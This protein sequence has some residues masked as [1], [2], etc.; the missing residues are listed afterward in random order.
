MKKICVV[1]GSRAEYGLL[2]NLMKK[3]NKDKN[4][5]L[6][7]IATCM[8]LLPKFGLTYKEIIKDGF[9]INWTVKM[10]ISSSKPINVTK[11]TGLG[12]VGF[13]KAFAKLKPDIIIILGD[14]FE[15]LSAA[16]AALSEKIPIAHIHGGESTTGVIDEAIRHS[17]SKMS[18][19]H[20]VATKKYGKRIMQ[21]GENPNRIY[22]V[23]S[24]GVD[25]IKNIKLYSKD[26]LEKKINFKLG[27][28]NILV[29]YHP[30]TLNN[31]S[32][33]KDIEAIIQSIQK[34]KK[35]KI[36][37]TLPNADSGSEVILKTIKN[38][39][40]KNKNRSIAF[41]SMGDKLYLSTMKNSDLVLG[42]SSSGIIEAPSFKIPTINVG[43]RQN[44]RIKAGSI[45]DCDAKYSS[46]KQAIKKAFSKKFNKKISKVKNPYELK[47]TSCKIFN[48]LKKLKTDNVLKKDFY[49]LP[50]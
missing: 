29:T 3:L 39:V 22:L 15:I 17:V 38:F 45:I 37:F 7:I 46:I 50:L 12:M 23:G 18:T 33:K 47:D 2:Y 48:T 1:T 26:I 9:K 40:K 49:D 10:P 31:N 25:R 30:V 41:K 35:A 43:D 27:A 13:A 5:K 28:K 20:F 24:L 14:R 4:I 36:I 8:H 44:G 21:L 42:N 34:I 16:F 11:A 19:W 6:Q 32:E